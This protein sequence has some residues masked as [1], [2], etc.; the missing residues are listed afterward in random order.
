MLMEIIRKI[1]ESTG[2]TII[3]VEHNMN[4]VMN[5]SDRITVMHQGQVLA[6]GT[7]AEIRENPAVQQAYLGE[8]YTGS[9]TGD[10]VKEHV[11]PAPG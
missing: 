7:P 8:S 9:M 5:I 6:E 3:L 4:I 11:E 2:K 10:G 1:M